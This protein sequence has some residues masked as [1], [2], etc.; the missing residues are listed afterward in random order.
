LGNA[1]HSRNIV[2]YNEL[3]DT[4]LECSDTGA[5]NCWMEPEPRDGLRQGHIIRYNLIVRSGDRAIYLD[6]YTSNCHVYG[7]VLVGAKT[8][9]IF[10]HAGKNNVIENNV[11]AD[12]GSALLEGVWIDRFMPAMAGFLSGNRFTQNIVYGCRGTVEVF[13][14][15]AARAISQADENVFFNTA[16]AASYLER[17]RRIG[18]ER[19][20]LLAD[21]LFVDPAKQDYRLQPGSPALKLGFEPINVARIGPRKRAP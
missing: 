13:D 11:F 3:R 17:Q 6:N 1:G 14:V 9:A 10:V 16:G 7:N 15:P 5:L 8:A 4:C 21:P 2:E 20:S 12:C 18:L 19:H